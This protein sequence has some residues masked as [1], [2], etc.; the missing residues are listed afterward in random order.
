MDGPGAAV[1]VGP[2]VRIGPNAI[3]RVAE[4]LRH[5]QG[6][7]LLAEVFGRAGLG[8]YLRCPPQHMVDEGEVVRLHAVL[9][10]RLGAAAARRIGRDAGA[11]TGAYL[12][13]HRI[14]RAA[15]W[16]LRGLPAGAATRALTTAIGRHAWTFAGSAR[17]AARAGRPVHLVLADCPLCRATRADSACCDFYAACFEHLFRALVHERA[18]VRETACAAL[19]ADACRFEVHW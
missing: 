5:Q 12:L 1:T 16:L 19:G 14:P 10:E 17:F 6:A 18:T 11:R 9:R 15:R 8:H 3:T 7:D 4:A 13:A 2:P